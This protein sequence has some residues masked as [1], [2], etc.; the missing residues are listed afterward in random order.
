MRSVENRA[1][2]LSEAPIIEGNSPFLVE[3]CRDRAAA[4]LLGGIMPVK[5]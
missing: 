3:K 1:Y 2:K 5:A 4:K